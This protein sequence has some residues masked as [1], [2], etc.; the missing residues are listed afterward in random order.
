MT[1]F[2]LALL[3]AVA[4]VAGA[5]AVPAGAAP[6]AHA[7]EVS[8][9]VEHQRDFTLPFAADHVAVHWAGDHDAA[10]TVAVSLDGASFTEAADAGRDEVGEQRGDGETYGTL[11]PAEGAT[12]VRVASDRPLGRLS[13]LALQ[14]GG[15][16]AAAPAATSG[17]AII[18]RSGWGADESLRFRGKRE[19]WPPDFRPVEKTVVHHTAT[20]N[21]YADAAAAQAEIR[22]IYYYHAVTQGWG[23]I[24]YNFL[25]DR[26]GHV[27]EGRHSTDA[28]AVTGEKDGRI[29]TAGHAY[30]RNA[31][32]VGIAVLGTLSAQLPSA[33][34]HDAL[35]GMLAW[36]VDRHHLDPLDAPTE[37]W[38]DPG[39]QLYTNVVNGLEQRFPVV[40]GHRDVNVGETECP[41]NAFYPAL[42]ALRQD[43]AAVPRTVS[44]PDVTRPNIPT[45]AATVNR[46]KGKT[47]V[48]LSWPDQG[49]DASGSGMNG[50]KVFRGVEATPGTDTKLATVAVGT[51][52]AGSTYGY[53]DT[54]AKPGVRYA[55]RIGAFDAAGNWRD[56]TTVLVTP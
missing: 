37:S 52:P 43:V 33:A 10:V 21:D 4:L 49:D 30:Q 47:A 7:A 29:V 12:A 45:L 56:S 15:G 50:W 48:Q 20:T 55:Y 31:G 40:A 26:F 9:P 34:A 51:G 23:D 17:P 14:D 1:R 54:T 24:G 3:A 16:P 35:V 41:G 5:P 6:H 13:V 18:L 22:A 27:Y 28:V 8:A 46:A 39:G 53:T 19:I 42:G 25:V 32:T 2:S 44:S 11:V 38:P 36:E